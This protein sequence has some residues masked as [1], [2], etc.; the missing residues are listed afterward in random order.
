MKFR[1][2]RVIS[3]MLPHTPPRVKSNHT[4]FLS[5]GELFFDE[6][7]TWPCENQK[8]RESNTLLWTQLRRRKMKNAHDETLLLILQ[9][10]QNSLSRRKTNHCTNNHTYAWPRS[11]V[12]RGGLRGNDLPPCAVPLALRCTMWQ[13]LAQIMSAALYG[14]AALLDSFFRLLQ[15]YIDI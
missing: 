8:A 12:N 4:R 1:W 3:N 10:C 6:G 11:R 2:A 13:S 15:F 7:G 5:E 14:L 9:A